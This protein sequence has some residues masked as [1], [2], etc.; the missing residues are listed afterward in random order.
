MKRSSNW[1]PLAAL[2]AA[3]VSAAVHGDEVTGKVIDLGSSRGL[4]GVLISIRDLKDHEVASGSTDGVGAYSVAIPKGQT[5]P[6]TAQFRKPNFVSDPTLLTIKQ[7]K[8]AQDSVSMV[9]SEGTT[10]YYNRAVAELE[11]DTSAA[12]RWQKAWAV[13][14]LPDADQQLVKAQLATNGHT[15]IVNDVN[16]ARQT[17]EVIAAVSRNVR[18]GGLP[19]V[20]VLPNNSSKLVAIVPDS[21]SR[22]QFAKVQ[23]VLNDAKEKADLQGQGVYLLKPE[24]I[25]NNSAALR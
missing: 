12:Q 1:R 17:Q 22:V 9:Q 25:R 18:D 19:H 23:S 20:A 6:M 16:K 8:T 3:L 13:A 11:Q 5:L 2:L 4:P 14:S 10:A 21:T 7:T 15:D 24:A